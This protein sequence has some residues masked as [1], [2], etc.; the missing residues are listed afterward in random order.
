MPG[1]IASIGGVQGLD[2]GLLIDAQHHCVLRRGEV[3]PD[4][5]GDLGGSVENLKVSHRHGA[6]PYSRHARAT[7]ASPI[8]QVFRE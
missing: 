3:E 7:V 2:L 1:C 8:F 4:D 5:I 6:T